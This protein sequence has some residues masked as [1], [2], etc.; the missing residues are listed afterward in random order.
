MALYAALRGGKSVLYVVNVREGTLEE[1][2]S[3]YAAI[4]S[5]QRVTRDAVV[6]RGVRDDEGARA[7]LCSLK[8]AATPTFTLLGAGAGDEFAALKP[9]VAMPQPMTLAV[10]GTGEPVH[11]L[12]Y[13][14]TNPD[15][16]APDGEKPPAV[17]YAHGGPT[18]IVQQGLSWQ[19]TFYTSRGFA[20]VGVNYGGSSGYGRKYM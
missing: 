8:D 9:Y 14:P 1:L 19:R 18:S 17:F 5:V 2:A 7:V 3:P 13:P 10:P 16:I 15:Y 11:V 12:F 6:F 20:W 4:S